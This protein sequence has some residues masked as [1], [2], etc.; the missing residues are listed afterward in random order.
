[1][2]GVEHVP[3]QWA[4]PSH[5]T[6]TRGQMRAHV[7]VDHIMQG[8]LS[9]MVGWTRTGESRVIAHF[10]IGMAGRIVQF[11]DIYTEGIHVSSVNSPSS[12]RVQQF[13]SIAGRGVNPYSIGIEHEG[14]SIDPRPAYSVPPGMLY[15][16]ANP[17]PSP[18]VEASIRVKR[19]IFAQPNTYLGPPSRDSII[20][21]YEA[22]LRNRENDPADARA[23]DVWP[24]QRMI[25]ALAPPEEDDMDG[26]YVVP[27]GGSVSRAAQETGVSIAELVRL[28]G[29]TNVNEVEAFQPLRLNDRVEQPPMLRFNPPPGPDVMPDLI[30]ADSAMAAARAAIA[31]ARAKIA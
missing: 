31:A 1:M 13:G 10:G 14:A 6:G 11:S 23:R 29:I 9:T 5:I 12:K 16:R 18:M 22:D 24:V 26:W 21:H 4:L 30:A 17:W 19:W 20:G 25:A 3:I 2:P 28:N 15:S 8:Y 7:V 27:R